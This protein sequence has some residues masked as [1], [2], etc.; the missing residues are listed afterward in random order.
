MDQCHTILKR[1]NSYPH[2]AEP[3]GIRFQPDILLRDRHIY[4]CH[5]LNRQSLFPIY[6]NDHSRR[7]CRTSGIGSGFGKFLYL[8]LI[9]YN[10]KF[11]R[12][13]IARAWRLHTCL[14]NLKDLFLLYG[15]IFISTDTYS[16]KNILH[17][18]SSCLTVRCFLYLKRDN[19]LLLSW[20]ILSQF[21]TGG[22]T[23]FLKTFT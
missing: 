13:L 10:I 5:I 3:Q 14:Q 4:L 12:L 2:A 15:F 8:L 19:N 21:F 18:N 7:S 6:R 1:R 22:Q 17:A 11:P 9:C 23:S 20:T 16:M